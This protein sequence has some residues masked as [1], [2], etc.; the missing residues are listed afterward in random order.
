MAGSW[1]DIPFSTLRATNHQVWLDFK[2][3]GIQG[4]FEP[5]AY[6]VV[7][8]GDET[9]MVHATITWTTASNSRWATGTTGR[10]KTTP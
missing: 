10:A 1:L 8:L 2:S 9:V 5:P 3:H 7:M 4:S 6:C